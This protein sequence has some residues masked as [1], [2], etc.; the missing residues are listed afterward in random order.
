[1]HEEN[2][3]V[4]RLYIVSV[5]RP[6]R[7]F[8]VQRVGEHCSLKR[9]HEEKFGVKRLHIVSVERPDEHFSVQR[10][11]EHCSVKRVHVQYGTKGKATSTQTSYGNGL[12][13]R[14]TN[15]IQFCSPFWLCRYNST[16]RQSL[17][18]KVKSELQIRPWC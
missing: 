13:R 14:V 10:V 5:K 8:S 9:V 1:M 17:L 2:F 16:C 18:R 4:K 12:F 7:H 11:G 3:G 6:D 15:R